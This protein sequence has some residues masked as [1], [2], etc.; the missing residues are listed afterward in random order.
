MKR[1]CFTLIELLVVIAIIAILAAMLLPALNQARERARSTSCLSNLNQTG[2]VFRMYLDD[3]NGVLLTYSSNPDCYWNEALNN[4]KPIREDQ[5]S[6]FCPSLRPSGANHDTFTT[7]GAFVAA[8]ALPAA[9]AADTG[10]ASGTNWNRVDREL[11]ST[12]FIGCCARANNNAGF[13][14]MRIAAGSPGGFTNVHNNRG[15]LAYSDGHAGS[16]TPQEFRE[17]M[18]KVWKDDAKVIYYRD[19]ADGFKVIN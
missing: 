3:Y 15:N 13:Y 19:A 5:K 17:T 18:R 7:Y 9:Y 16:S 14:S 8:V 4:R 1:Y 6:Y 2:T 12:P 11:G 10:G